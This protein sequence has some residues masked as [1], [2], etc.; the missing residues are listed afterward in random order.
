MILADPLRRPGLVYQYAFD[1]L[2]V[3]LSATSGHAAALVSTLFHGVELMR[4][5][6]ALPFLEPLPP[7]LIRGGLAL[8]VSPLHTLAGET[9]AAALAWLEPRRADAAQMPTIR[10]RLQP[11]GLLYLLA[12]GPLARFLAERQQNEAAGDPWPAAEAL[13]TLTAAGFRLQ[14]AFALHGLEAVAWHCLGEGC[15][16]LGQRHWRDRAHFAMRRAFVTPFS[17]YRP[18]AIACLTLER[19]P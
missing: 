7:E 6:S 4:R 11:G 18:F 16:R 5:L 13:T 9:E 12:A 8:G 19:L 10:Q 1:W 2:A 14:S 17:P 15:A 3:Q